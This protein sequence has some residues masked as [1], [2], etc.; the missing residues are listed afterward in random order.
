MI[1]F[2]FEVCLKE[3][4]CEKFGFVVNVLELVALKD[5]VVLADEVA[6]W[7]WKGF[8]QTRRLVSSESWCRLVKQV[9]SS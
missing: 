9:S 6:K 2:I 8:G 4:S 5:Y 7:T 3:L 1:D